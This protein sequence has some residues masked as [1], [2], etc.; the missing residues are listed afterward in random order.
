M[1]NNSNYY[2]RLGLPRNAAQEEIRSAY[3]EAARKLHPDTNPEKGAV[4]LFLQVQEAYEV[5]SNPEKRA[6]YDAKLTL[7][8]STA[9]AVSVNVIYSRSSIPYLNE[10]QLVYVLLE[11]IS[12]PEA[13]KDTS[14]PLNICLVLDRSTSMQGARMD[15]VKANAIQM[16]RQM[17]PKDLISIVA[18]SDRA[19][20]VVNSTHPT[21][22]SKIESRI[23]M[24]QPG[25]S[26]EIYQ[27]LEAGIE[28]L[29]RSLSQAYINHLILLTDGRTYGDEADCL[30][31][32][33]EVANEGI[34]ISGLGIGHEWNDAFLDNLASRN[35]GSSMYISAPRDLRKYLEQKFSNLEKVYAEK[36]VLELKQNDNVELRYTFRLQPE[37]GQLTTQG[38]IRVGNIVEFEKPEYPYGIHDK[39]SAGRDDGINSGEGLR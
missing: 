16:L 15:M 12:V 20:V 13:G 37:S 32:A 33:E 14:T 1:V 22:I 29:R 8:E 27:G 5:L 11:M 17:R 34:G 6:A 26:T 28:Q 23:S 2:T 39:R 24:L 3:F 7:N 25:G 30:R 31:L 9:P 21:D 35:G 4:E 38:P 10:P 19:E 36:V 18:F